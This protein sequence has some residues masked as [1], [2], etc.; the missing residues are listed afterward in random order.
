[1]KQ[2]LSSLTT[3]V[4]AGVL[5]GLETAASATTGFLDVNGTFNGLGFR[6]ASDANVT[7]VPEP[8]TLLGAVVGLVLLWWRRAL[9]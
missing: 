2:P 5:P 3:W 8:S 6:V 4:V 1:M 9:R 7:V